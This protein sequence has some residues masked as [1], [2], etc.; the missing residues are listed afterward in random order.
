MSVISPSAS[1]IWVFGL[2]SNGLNSVH[3]VGIFRQ[4]DRAMM[5]QGTVARGVGSPLDDGFRYVSVPETILEAGESYQAVAYR[6]TGSTDR[7]GRNFRPFSPASEITILRDI[8]GIGGGRLRFATIVQNVN[9][10]FGPNFKFEAV[11]EPSL[12]NFNSDSSV[13]VLDMDAFF[14]EV[15]AETDGGLFDLTGNGTVDGADLT[16]WRTDAATHNG[17]GAPY[18]VGDSNLGGSV[19]AAGLNNVALNWRQDDAA[20]WS[21][22]DFKVDGSVNA[23]DLNELALNWQQSIPMAST[24]GAAVPEPSAI[25]LA[26]FGLALVWR[27]QRCS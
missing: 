19:N 9:G 2:G 24:A 12:L 20:R 22:G 21:A 5:V 7:V 23:L 13:D 26:A 11:P 1:A 18:L 10:W 8:L 17:F 4:S 16:K 6:P 14:G 27:R 25:V 15:V 3:D